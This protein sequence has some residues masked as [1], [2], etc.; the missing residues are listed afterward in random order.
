MGGKELLEGEAADE[1]EATL[2]IRVPRTLKERLAAKAEADDVSLNI[3][4]MR[5]VERSFEGVADA[6]WRAHYIAAYIEAVPDGYSE[7]KRLEAIQE[8][9]ET[10]E[11][12]WLDL[13]LP[14]KKGEDIREDIILHREGEILQE[15]EPYQD[16]QT[17]DG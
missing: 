14:R 11:S 6:L 4:V 15:W 8:M 9:R 16:D 12:V 13:G 7:Q 1:H 3:F 10:I 17:S 2:Y 5:C